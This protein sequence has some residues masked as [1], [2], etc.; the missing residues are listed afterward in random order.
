MSAYGSC[1]MGDSIIENW[2]ALCDDIRH[3]LPPF[4]AR[5]A[6][7]LMALGDVLIIRLAE[8][9][10]ELV[11]LRYQAECHN[12]LLAH[13]R[14]DRDE[15]R[16]RAERAEARYYAI[17]QRVSDLS[18]C[19]PDTRCPKIGRDCVGCWE[20]LVDAAHSQEVAE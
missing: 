15:Q 1:A 9:D 20:S 4:S 10:A 13:T 3:Q 14:S 12:T 17:L 7:E 19:P 5:Q 8:R 11:D 2:A 6:T 18:E 16:R